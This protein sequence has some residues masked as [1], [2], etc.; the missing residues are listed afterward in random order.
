MQLF[1]NR[2]NKLPHA[3]ESSMYSQRV[4]KFVIKRGDVMPKQV[5]LQCL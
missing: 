5:L 2:H 1:F 3:T 4:L